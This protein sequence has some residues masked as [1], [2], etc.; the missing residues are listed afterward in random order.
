MLLKQ[1]AKLTLVFT[2]PFFYMVKPLLKVGFRSGIFFWRKV[3]QTVV[4]GTVVGSR[5]LHISV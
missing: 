3:V 1:D 2:R 5:V 4:K